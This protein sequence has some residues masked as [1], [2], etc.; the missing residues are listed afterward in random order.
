MRASRDKVTMSS[1][2]DSDLKNGIQALPLYD[3]V[4]LFSFYN[5]P[6]GERGGL[7][8]HQ[9]IK[10]YKSTVAVAGGMSFK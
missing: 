6:N 4:V 2:C 10:R 9:M 3:V 5:R 1:A 7:R 8:S